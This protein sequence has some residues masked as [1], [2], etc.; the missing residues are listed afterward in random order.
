VITR[1]EEVLALLEA[2]EA[3]SAA[4]RLASDL[5][6]FAAAAVRRMAALPAAPPPPQPQAKPQPEPSPLQQALAALDPDA[7]TP[8]DALDLLYRWKR[9]F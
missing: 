9:T 6:L 5:P 7:L 2:D 1:A 8:K 4:A 3:T